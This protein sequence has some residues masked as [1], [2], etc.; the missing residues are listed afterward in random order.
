[1]D[2]GGGG[3][4]KVECETHTQLFP[5]I[6]KKTSIDLFRNQL[7]CKLQELSKDLFNMKTFYD[8]LSETIVI[9]VYDSFFRNYIST[10]ACIPSNG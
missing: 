5:S 3:N 6:Y 8:W 7:H 1:M 2:E 9:S 4:N 10:G